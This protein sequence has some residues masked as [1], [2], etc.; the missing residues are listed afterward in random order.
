MYACTHICRELSLANFCQGISAREGKKKKREGEELPCLYT[1]LQSGA[2][3]A[4]WPL[5]VDGIERSVTSPGE[6]FPYPISLFNEH[7]A[8]V[9]KEKNYIYNL[10]YVRRTSC[11]KKRIDRVKKVYKH[12]LQ[13][14][15]DTVFSTA[16]AFQ[17]LSSNCLYSLQTFFTPF[18]CLYNHATLR[19]QGFLSPVRSHV[20][21]TRFYR[22]KKIKC[23]KLANN[24]RAKVVCWTI[25]D[26]KNA[27]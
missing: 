15:I 27:V 9:K 18:A 12:E 23:K 5:P 19:E 22:G 2:R 26:I 24:S 13:S 11:C 16:P 8:R 14:S 7:H 4:R 3:H 25:R 21:I 6:W 20:I 17:P 1:Y 10:V